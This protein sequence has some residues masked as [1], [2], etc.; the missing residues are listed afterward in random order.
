[1]LV[2]ST[3]FPADPKNNLDQIIDIL[4]KWVKGSPHYP[5]GATYEIPLAGNSISECELAGHKLQL[6]KL[7]VDE[8]EY[9]GIRYYWVEDGKNEWTTEITARKSKNS[10]WITVKLFCDLVRPGGRLPAPNKPHVIGLLFNGLGG[11]VDGLFKASQ[12][13]I[14]LKPTE[15]DIAVSIVK[16]ENVCE[17]PVVYISVDMNGHP[18]FDVITLARWL[19][20]IA[21]IIVEPN[22]RFSISLAEKT[23]G[24]NPY[25]G[26]ACVFWPNG[27]GRPVKIK[28]VNFYNAH[29]AQQEITKVVRSALIHSKTKNGISWLGIKDAYAKRSLDD[30]RANAG[31][32]ID[33]Y[34]KAFDEQNKTLLAELDQAEEENASL[35]EA[36]RAMQA[37]AANSR[38]GIIDP[39]SEN[40]F[41]PGELSDAILVSLKKSLSMLGQGTRIKSLVEDIIDKNKITNNSEKFELAVKGII[42]EKMKMTAAEVKELEKIG[43]VVTEDGK[44]YKAV[45]N[46]DPR[47]T[48]SIF[49][50]A[51]DH[52][53]GKNCA[54][55]I[56]AKIS[57]R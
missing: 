22:R 44:H 37:R 13:P 3:E 27:S 29:E 8:C 17:M 23:S 53:S 50:T 54:G 34:I 20:G 6:A 47:Y 40:E 55:D 7:F 25:S 2:F 1:M 42:S 11:G 51:S 30:V 28:P 38:D 32:G 39:G 49:K 52:R 21:H 9:C 57:I 41:Y 12:S 16:G 4:N 10:L 35:K 19:S 15:I 26:A 5:W 18:I 14:Y 31:S 36:L 48:F 43:F 56:I 46:S 45:Y 33:D 24:Q